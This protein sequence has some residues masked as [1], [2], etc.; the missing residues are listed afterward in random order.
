LFHEEAI[1]LKEGRSFSQEQYR[2]E[3]E[4]AANGIMEELAK[5]RNYSQQD[6][7]GKIETLSNAGTWTKKVALL[8]TGSFVIFSVVFSLYINR[9]I[10]QPISILKKKTKQIA[11]GEFEGDLSLS[12]P[13]EIGELSD[14]FNFMCNQLKDL[15]K[16]KSDFFSSMSHELRTPLTSIK[17][18]IG[19]LYE[20]VGGV[21]TERQRKLLT[22]LTEESNRLIDLVNSLLDLAKMEAGMMDY[23][24]EKESLAPLIDKT[25]TEVGP[26]AEARKI[27]LEAK[28]DGPLPIL[29]V[30]RERIL[31]TIRNLLGN[32]LKFTPGGGRVGVSARPVDQ[33][34][35]VSVTDTGPGIPME[36][37]TT[38]FEKFRRGD[39]PGSYRVNGTGLGL[40][41]AK[42]I[43]TS[44][45]G[46]IWAESKVGYG[47]TFIFVLPV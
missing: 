24:F 13:P 41:I 23:H 18:G 14:A 2:R 29:M 15:D 35:E 44:H 31:Q 19:L 9:S 47:S 26:L 40:A 42:H 32:A 12:S 37:L 46:Q 33:G 3:K 34:V 1:Y 6:A 10:T 30:D 20:G 8:M 11:K 22:I 36:N 38:I 4:K 25:L 7:Y 17:E 5:L 27:N 45:K 43:I 39:P 21:I 28:I 16:L